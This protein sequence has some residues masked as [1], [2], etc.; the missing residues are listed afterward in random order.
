MVQTGAL[1]KIAA[2][3]VSVPWWRDQ[4]YYDAPGRGSY[5]QDGGGVLL[6]QA[7]HTL[8]LALWLFGPVTRVQA[9]ARRT[10]LHQMEAEDFVSAGLEFAN[11]AAGM[12]FAS[13]A[14]FPG[15]GEQ[16]TV[17]ASAGSA[18]LSAGVLSVHWQDGREEIIGTQ[19]ASGG[20]ADPMA[21]THAWHQAVI[22]D[23]ATSLAAG[24]PPL[25]PGREALQVHALIEALVASSDAGATK[26]VC[27][28]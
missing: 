17:H 12:L 11:G 10:S 3:E 13:T 27:Y 14:S 26:E 9:M 25:C 1:G 8:D 5:A 6:T 16:I 19:A 22:E 4:H 15:R 21:F 24:Q 2:I 28:V 7:I 20:G 18:S 23:F